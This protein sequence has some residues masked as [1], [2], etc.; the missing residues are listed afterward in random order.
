MSIQNGHLDIIKY[1]IKQGANIHTNDDFALR[2]NASKGHLNIV[3][4]L[5][6]NGANIH[7]YYIF[8]T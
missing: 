7:A 6:K 1:L 5:I 4:Y 2:Y 8:R 3:K